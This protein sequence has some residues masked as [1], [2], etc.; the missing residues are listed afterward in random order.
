MHLIPHLVFDGQCKAAFECYKEFLG[1][2]IV[3][4]LTYGS[5]TGTPSAPE[6]KDKIFHATLKFGDQKITG[7][8]VEHSFYQ[9]PRGF[10][11]QLNLDHPDEA[12]RI[13]YILSES[14]SVHLPLQQTSWA[15]HYASLTDRFGIPWE[16]NCGF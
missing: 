6:L 15:S 5:Q 13:F 8:D 9:K 3:V 1:G 12:R 4:M 16:I 7:V 10:S 14:G 2:D 11:I